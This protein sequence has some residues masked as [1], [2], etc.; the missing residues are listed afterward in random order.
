VAIDTRTHRFTEV[1]ACTTTP[2]SLLIEPPLLPSS[3]LPTLLLNLLRAQLAEKV[4]IHPAVAV[5][6][7]RAQSGT[8]AWRVRH[9]EHLLERKARGMINELGKIGGKDDRE[10][11]GVFA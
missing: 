11:F 9:G 4:P 1:H 5:G 10:D 8:E 7:M 3:P 2:S 6:L